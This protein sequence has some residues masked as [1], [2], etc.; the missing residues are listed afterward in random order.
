MRTLKRVELARDAIGCTSF[1]TA[2][3][4]EFPLWDV[5]DPGATHDGDDVQ[6]WMLGI[7]E[8]F[9]RNGSG[10][11]L[12]AYGVQIPPR[13][14]RESYIEKLMQIKELILEYQ[15]EVWMLGARPYHPSRWQRVTHRERPGVPFQSAVR[16]IMV[17]IDSSLLNT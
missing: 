9:L 6:S 8:H 1:V 2:N 16:E 3:L 4:Y 10:H 12:L 15:C 13:N 5:N 11:V 17:P 14:R 7:R